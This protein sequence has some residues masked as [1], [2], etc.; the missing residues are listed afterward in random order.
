MPMNVVLV[1][2]TSGLQQTD[3]R[4]SVAAQDDTWRTEMKCALPDPRQLRVAVL[5]F[6]VICAI[7]PRF[8]YLTK[9]PALAEPLRR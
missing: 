9:S 7:S 8:T 1:V 4:C 2:L 5:V 6:K 3:Q